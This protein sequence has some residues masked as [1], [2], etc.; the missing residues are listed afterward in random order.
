[1]RL[2]NQ[3]TDRVGALGARRGEVATALS[4]LRSQSG[5][6]LFVVYVRSFD[7]APARDWAD[8]TARR[9]DL[10]REDALLAVAT[11]DRAYAYS[12]TPSSRSPM[13]SSPT[14]PRLPSS[15]RWRAMTGR[16]RPSA[17]LT[18]TAPRWP[19]GRCRHRGS[20]PAIPI[21]VVAGQAC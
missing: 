10:G 2:D 1:M 14:S 17:R 7:G 11:G 5:L 16:G 15:L 13:I 9:S 12:S 19:A 4:A 3:I 8:E 20:N 21:P 6:Q 18:D